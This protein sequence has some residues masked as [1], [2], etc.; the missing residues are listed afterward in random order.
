MRIFCKTVFLSFSFLALSSVAYADDELDF[1]AEPSG[2]QEVPEVDT[3]TSGKL[4]IDFDLDFTEAKFRLKVRRGEK[5]TQA[6]LHCGRAGENG[7]VVAFLFGFVPG[8]VDVNGTLARGELTNDDITGADCMP[9]IGIPVNNIASLA[10][11]ALQGL[12]YVNVHTV[13][14]LSGEVRGQLVLEELLDD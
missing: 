1:E 4:D 6:H 14:N 9:G 8:G 5:V 11:A 3:R 12:I 10:S 2:A 13:A 7:L